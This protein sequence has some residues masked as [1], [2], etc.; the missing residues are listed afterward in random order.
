ML[1]SIRREDHGSNGRDP[2]FERRICL[3]VNLQRMC[4]VATHRDFAASHPSP[5][6]L[7]VKTSCQ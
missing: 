6:V 5:A 1:V 4:E 3:L 7:H 2:R